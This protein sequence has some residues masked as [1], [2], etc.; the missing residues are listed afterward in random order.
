MVLSVFWFF[1]CGSVWI[2]LGFVA[3]K[4]INGG[5]ALDLLLQLVATS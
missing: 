4:K 1:V 5:G 3:C 2:I